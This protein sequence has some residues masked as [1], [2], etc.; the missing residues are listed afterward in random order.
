MHAVTQYDRTIEDVGNVVIMEHVNT[1]VPDPQLATIFYATGLGLTR[2]PYMMTGVGNM[3]INVGR[4]Q[5]HLPTNTAQVVRGHVGLVVPDLEA[6][7][8][9][10][11][12]VRGMLAGTRFAFLEG[13]GYVDTVS[14][15]GNRV[16]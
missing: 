1:R 14:P 4:S 2:D 10:L 15:W 12:D 6:L 13:D 7:V 3:W 16:R 11:G 5:F 9:R 8:R